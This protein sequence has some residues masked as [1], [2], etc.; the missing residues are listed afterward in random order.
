MQNPWCVL[1]HFAVSESKF[2]DT[3]ISLV[4]ARTLSIT[5]RMYH[6]T[7]MANDT[8]VYLYYSPDGSNWDTVAYTSFALAYDA[9]DWV[10]RTV[11]IDVPEHGFIKVK[12]TN[13]SSSYTMTGVKLWYSIQ[14]WPVSGDVGH[15][16]VY[17][18]TGEERQKVAPETK[19]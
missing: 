6:A 8:V 19:G 2:A 12:V 7:G 1:G 18:D 9:D 17:V 10:Q 11:A 5:A 16:A 4:R 14:S 3:P 13:G 15:G